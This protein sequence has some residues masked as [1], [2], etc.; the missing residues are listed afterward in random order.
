MDLE[1]LA[2]MRAEEQLQSGAW[3]TRGEY[4]NGPPPMQSDARKS[5]SAAGRCPVF[6]CHRKVRARGLCDTHYRNAMRDGLTQSE[7]RAKRRAE[8]A[9]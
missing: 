6:G 5:A 3:R 1:A 9:A 4:E 7:Y 8:R 2:V